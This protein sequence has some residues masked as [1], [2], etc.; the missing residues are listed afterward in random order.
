MKRA[1]TLIELLVVIAIIA[2]LAAILFPVFAQAKVAAK[3]AKG[4]AEIKQMATAT[5]IYQSDFDDLFPLGYGFDASCANGGWCLNYYHAVPADWRPGFPQSYVDR[6]LQNPVNSTQPYRKNYQ[7]VKIDAGTT[8]S[9]AV[10][11]TGA[12]KTP[13][14][15]GYTYNG[16]LSGY[17][18]TAVNQ[19]SSTPMWHAMYGNINVKG[20]NISSPALYCTN[21]AA[22]CNYVPATASCSGANG[23][24]TV[25]II[26]ATQA[27]FGSHHIYGNGEN[28]TYTDSSAKFKKLGMQLNGAS[29]F[30]ND[31]WTRY[32]SGAR[33][34]GG[35]YDQWY[36]HM[37]AFTP[38]WDGQA[39]TAPY[40]EVWY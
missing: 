6:A 38:D 11:Y 24:W 5:I 18:G 13:A 34:G 39:P 19:I 12:L 29:D 22:A 26:E 15:T 40:E 10:T 16:L 17:N 9:L 14:D 8:K 28:W 33:P 30:R 1:F 25:V 23:T 37:Y 35:W 4:L 32:D 36:C 31:P 2:I 3:K 21:G 27:A 20:F 7:M